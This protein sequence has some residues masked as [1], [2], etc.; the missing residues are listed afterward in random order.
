MKPV[1]ELVRLEESFEHGTFGALK[2]NKELFCWTLEPRDEENAENIS[3]I[4]AQQYDCRRYSSARY[5]DTFQVMDVP[6]RFN[7]LIHAG[8]T[9]DD[10]A[11]CILLGETLGKFRDGRAILNS[12]A[13]FRRFMALLAEHDELSLT[14][15]EEF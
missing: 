2:I 8:N 14:I 13:T 12:G 3:S 15:R 9:D 5:P 10:T 7:V 1:I 6:G 11:G 4:P